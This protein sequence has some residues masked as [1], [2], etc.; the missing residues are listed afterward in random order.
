MKSRQNKKNDRNRSELENRLKEELREEIEE[1]ISAKQAEDQSES[2]EESDATSSLQAELEAANDKLLRSR[3]EFDNF[4]KR[5]ARDAERTRLKAAAG[6]L[7]DLLPVL[8]NLERALEHSDDSSS[9]LHE[10]VEMVVKQL[11]DIMQR[12]GLTPI[13]ALGKAFDPQFHEAVA[14]AESDEYEKDMVSQEYQKG[15]GLGDVVLRP[16]KVVVSTGAAGVS[17]EATNTEENSQ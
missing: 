13:E 6:L 12:N 4:R 9:P 5:V 7:G 17:E 1:E 11:A 2:S 14:Q 10:G 15:Y 8:D 3:A 16:S